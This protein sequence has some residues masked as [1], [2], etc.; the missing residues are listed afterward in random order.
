MLIPLVPL[1]SNCEKG[2]EVLVY[3]SAVALTSLNEKPS[4]K[5]MLISYRYTVYY[6][7][8]RHNH[9]LRGMKRVRLCRKSV[10]EACGN[11]E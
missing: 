10:S 3:I 9:C 8:L 5:L 11:A 7:T 2:R 1:S 4:L 6:S